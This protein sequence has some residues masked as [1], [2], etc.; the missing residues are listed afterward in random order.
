MCCLIALVGQLSLFLHDAF[1][2]G[3]YHWFLLQGINLIL[4]D[5]RFEGPF[6]AFSLREEDVA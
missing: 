3:A 4:G 2:S 1:V 5:K 6:D